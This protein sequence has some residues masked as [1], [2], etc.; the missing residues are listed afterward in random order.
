LAVSKIYFFDAE[1]EKIKFPSFLIPRELYEDP[2]DISIKNLCRSVKITIPVKKDYQ[3]SIMS[4]VTLIFFVVFRLYVLEKGV[5]FTL[6]SLFYSLAIFLYVI[7]FNLI[8]FI[9]KREIELT[10][11]AVR[12]TD[13]SGILRFETLYNSSEIYN[14]RK[15]KIDNYTYGANPF[16]VK[17]GIFFDSEQYSKVCIAIASEEDDLERIY[18]ILEL[19]PVFRPVRADKYSSIYRVPTTALQERNNHNIDN[20]DDDDD[21]MYYADFPEDK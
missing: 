17:Y 21:E 14:L 19:S 12:I 9:G 15:I 10:G 1:T 4:V 3:A 8:K 5:E 11:N 7:N 2:E 16:T 6:F 18:R 20:R 13:Y